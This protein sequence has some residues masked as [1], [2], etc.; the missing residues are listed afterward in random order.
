MARIFEEAGLPAGTFNLVTGSGRVVG[1]GGCE[2]QVSRGPE[3]DF[4]P[5]AGRDSV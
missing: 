1:F 2:Q 3:K 5:G 4:R